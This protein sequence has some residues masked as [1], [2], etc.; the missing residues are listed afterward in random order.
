MGLQ[1][2]NPLIVLLALDLAG[3]M[4]AGVAAL[5]RCA[6]TPTPFLLPCAP[7]QLLPTGPTGLTARLLEVAL[8]AQGLVRVPVSVGPMSKMQSGQAFCSLAMS[9]GSMGIG[10]SESTC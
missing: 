3:A 4:V 5:L 9:M 8:A 6:E 7:L 10:R 1:L 2:S